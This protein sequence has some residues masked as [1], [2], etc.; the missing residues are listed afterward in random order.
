MELKIK[1]RVRLVIIKDS[2]ILLTYTKD[3]DF[4]FYIG[5]KMEFGETLE[6]TC[7][8]EVHEECGEEINFKFEKVLYIRDY[9]DLS[10]DEHSIEFYMLG[11]IDKTDGIEEKIDEEYP[12]FHKQVWVELNNLPSNLYPKS[13]SKKLKKD[14]EQNFPEQG[15]YLG[16]ID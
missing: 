6:E 12:D 5:G 13:L 4:Y 1:P 14:F 9:I 15:Q 11:E 7:I 2:K 16:P 8:R 3:G 10:K